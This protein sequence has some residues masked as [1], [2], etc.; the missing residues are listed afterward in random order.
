MAAF[1]GAYSTSNLS[2]LFK[3]VYGD[4]LENLIPE[5]AKF[6]KK[7]PFVPKQKELGNLYHQPVI[8][9]HAH[10]RTFANAGSG[11]FALN[12][13]V[14]GQ[15]KD[16]QVQGSQFL[17]REAID[18]ESAARAAKGRN[19]FKDTT[20]HVVENMTKSAVKTLECELMYGQSGLAT[21]GSV[22]AGANAVITVTT[23]EWAAG[24]WSGSEQMKIDIWDATLTT[25]RNPSTDI[26]V[27]AVDLSARTI[28]TDANSTTLGIVAT[29]VL[30]FKGAKGNEMAGLHKIVTNTGTLFNI[31]SAT[32]SL[33]KA[34][35]V[36]ASSAALSFAK[37]LEGSG[38]AVE[39]GVDGAMVLFCNT[40]T[41]NNLM[42]ELTALRRFDSSY[43]QASLKQ[44]SQEIEYY[45]Q[46]GMISIVPSTFVK[47]G[48]AY[49]IDPKKFMRVGTTDITFK[50]PG[51]EEEFFHQLP[52]H[53][54]YELRCYTDQALFCKAI[55]QQVYFSGIVNS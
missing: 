18:Y 45:G 42:T 53:A 33:W 15:I 48:Y 14:P 10:G 41:W 55:G 19:A 26:T 54:G 22:T 12:D 31:S 16:A 32:Y 43:S 13:P 52:S 7:V 34:S 39:K 30:F 25:Q 46:N 21:V 4:S 40:R 6:I 38:K 1:T 8:L 29:D 47:E 2:G 17:L 49:L 5:N 3:E 37:V 11:A 23:A 51:R 20:Q 9:G 35:T 24:I 27:T 28:T 50:V 44:G 36:S